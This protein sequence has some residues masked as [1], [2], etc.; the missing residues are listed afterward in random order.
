[1]PRVI[2]TPVLPSSGPVV[3]QSS[4][5]QNAPA[6]TFDF[7]SGSGFSLSGVPWWGWALG[8]GALLFAMGGKR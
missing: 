6:S 5:V 1:M 8:G 4:G 7:G 3:I 2:A